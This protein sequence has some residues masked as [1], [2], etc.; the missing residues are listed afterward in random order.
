[1]TYAVD[2]TEDALTALATIWLG[3]AHRQAITAA[4]AS[5]DRQL[6]SHPYAGSRVV[7]EGL[8][9]LDV[10]PLRALFEVNDAQH[11]VTIVAVRELP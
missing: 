9:S 6:A 10:P 11:V 8:Y 1:M 3:S 7:S 4:Q 5:L 2:W